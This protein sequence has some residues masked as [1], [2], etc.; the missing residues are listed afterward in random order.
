MQKSIPALAG[1]AAIAVPGSAW[2]AALEQAVPAKNVTTVVKRYT[3]PSVG[4]EFGPVQVTV[5]VKTTTTVAGGKKKVVRKLSDVT[6]T[7][8]TERPRSAMI[9]QQAVPYLRSEALRAQS[10]AIDLISGATLTSEAFA[11]SL[12]AALHSA[13]MK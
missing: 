5:T 9:N 10:A 2:A 1:A 13:G 11:Q 7:A 3:G 8:P 12:Q 4:M 6:A